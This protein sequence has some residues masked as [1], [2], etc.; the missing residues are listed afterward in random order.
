MSLRALGLQLH[1]QS[2][3][4]LTLAMAGLVVGFAMVNLVA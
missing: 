4:L 1:K 2:P 3:A